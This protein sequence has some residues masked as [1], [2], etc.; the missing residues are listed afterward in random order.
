M[1]G[2]SI[3]LIHGAW[4]GGWCWDAV[5]PLLS[6]RGHAVSAPTLTGLAEKSH[7]LA[8]DVSIGTFVDD[9]AEHLHGTDGDGIVL[10]GHSF[11]GTIL[12]S[13][14]ERMPERLSR[15]IYL[16]ALIVE[17]GIAPF[18]QFT[19]EVQASR[20]RKAAETSGGLSLPPPRPDMLGITDAAL[21]AE[22][23]PR[24]TPH[25]FRTFTDPAPFSGTVGAGLDCVYVQCVDPVYAPLAASRDWAQRAGWPVHDLQSGHDCMLI[26]PADTADLIHGLAMGAL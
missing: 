12:S 18:D 25:P 15:L 1:S 20:R 6:A 9:V 21:A 5:A 7:L 14:A 10:V 13:L 23:A 3:V 22:I 24:L 26:S 4:H 16:D 2:R 17:A 19:P 11:A 8:P